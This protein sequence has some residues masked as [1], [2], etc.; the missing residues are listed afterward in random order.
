MKNYRTLGI[1]ISVLLVFILTGCGENYSYE[2]TKIQANV[3]QCEEG[4]FHPDTSY[5][6][7]ANMYRTQDNLSM[8]SLYEGLANANGKYDY[9]VLV[10]IEG[11]SYIVVRSEQYEVGQTITITKLETYKDSELVKIEYK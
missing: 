8:W 2:E 7:I 5:Q 9:N 3:I 11:N 1:I 6:S 4:T 10:D